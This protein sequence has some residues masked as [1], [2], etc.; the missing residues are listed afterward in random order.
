MTV[1]FDPMVVTYDQDWWV[2]NKHCI[3]DKYAS[4]R[5]Q[6]LRD[7]M[8]GYR[9]TGEQSFGSSPFTLFGS[10]AAKAQRPAQQSEA[11]PE[12]PQNTRFTNK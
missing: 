10:N 5:D 12:Q 1:K 3:V 9:V 8:L 4:K 11:R 7:T 6:L 2:S